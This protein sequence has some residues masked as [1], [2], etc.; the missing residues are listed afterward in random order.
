MLDVDTQGLEDAEDLVIAKRPFGRLFGP[1]W[2]KRPFGR[3]FGSSK[4][5]R[6]YNWR[7]YS[8]I[9]SKS[10]RPFG[11]LF[12]PRFA[13]G[14]RS[15]QQ[16]AVDSQSQKMVKRPF[17]RMFGPGSFVGK[18]SPSQETIGEPL[19]EKSKRPFG[20]MFGP[21]FSTG[22]RSPLDEAFDTPPH[23]L[24]KRPFGRLF[25]TSV[26]G[27]RALGSVLNGGYKLGKRSATEDDMDHVDVSDYLEL[28][29]YS[30]EDI[31]KRYSWTMSGYKLGRR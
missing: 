3:L 24:Y 16:Q 14:K 18:R 17:G 2:S 11:R 29:G 15:G 22:K 26:L 9:L 13:M 19:Q 1:S 10:K 5:R 7:M 23:E 31:Q 12:G 6:P 4:P 30:P 20:R 28:P 21:R 8:Q 27:K 25:G